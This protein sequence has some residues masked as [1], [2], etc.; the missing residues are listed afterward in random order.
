MGRITTDDPAVADALQ[1]VRDLIL[2]DDALV[3]ARF[4]GAQHDTTIP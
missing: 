3:S 4:S 2:T 1:L